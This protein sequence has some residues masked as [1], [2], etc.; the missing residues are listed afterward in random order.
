MNQPASPARKRVHRQT[1][2]LSGYPHLVVIYLG[3][4]QVWRDF[5][6]LEAWTRSQPAANGGPTFCLH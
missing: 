4:R 5:D 6:S 3:M 2:D 1:V